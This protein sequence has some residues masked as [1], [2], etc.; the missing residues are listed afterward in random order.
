MR[1]FHDMSVFIICLVFNIELR[2]TSSVPFSKGCKTPRGEE[3]KTRN[4]ILKQQMTKLPYLSFKL[5]AS[6]M[7][8]IF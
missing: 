1:E 8:V 2:F 4:Q 5:M 7:T 3:I 6:F